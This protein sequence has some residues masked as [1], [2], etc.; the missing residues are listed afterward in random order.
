MGIVAKTR[1]FLALFGLAVLLSRSTPLVVG[2]DLT[3]LEF[4]ATDAEFL[5]PERGFYRF[6]DLTRPTNFAE[7]RGQGQTLIYGRVQASDFRDRPLS[8]EFLDKIQAG[9]DETRRQGLKVKF[10]LA[11]N[12]G[13]DADAP[14][15]VILNHIQQL[16][17]LWEKNKDVMFHMDAGF[18]GAW[19]EWHS[20]TNGLD[21]KNDR[22]DILFAILDALPADRTVGIRTPH[23]KREAFTGSQLSNK[24][25]ITE[26]NAFDGSH[27]AR[28]G[29]LNDC[30]LSSEDDV[31]T[32]AL[33]NNN[34]PLERELDYIGGE[35][36]YVPFGGE[37]CGLHDRGKSQ[38]ALPEMAQL[39]I[40][41]LNLDYHP[42]VIRRWKEEGSFDE[43]QRRLGYRFELKSAGLPA[44]LRPGGLMPL[45]FTIDNVGFGELFNP[46]RMEVTLRNN[47]TGELR[48]A[49]LRTDPRRWTGGETNEVTTWLVV[50]ETLPTGK[51]SVGLWLPDIDPALRDDVRYSIR[52]ANEQVWD[53]AT[54][55]NRLTSDFTI[56]KSAAGSVYE[57]A[58]TFREVVDPSL[59]NLK[60][61]FDRD[62]GLDA[63]DVDLLTAA[64][65][66][67]DPVFDLN[68]DGAVSQLD[69]EIWV[70]DL[71][72]TNFGDADLNGS[73]RVR[74]LH[75]AFQRIRLGW[76]LGEREF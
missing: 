34:W 58:T 49:A 35:S 29:H 28:V 15:D 6:R 38:N 37:T 64:V 14:K 59:L 53:A 24:Q 17:P 13:F 75:A 9:F 2:Q 76:G 7:V 25:V 22:H 63:D 42:D 11:Y 32:Y 68:R 23:F 66:S 19:G 69:R 62:G 73:S 70:E 26:Q 36:Q 21:N 4:Q 41:Y 40:D 20:S 61:D 60:G 30:F 31:G 48:T 74:G 8:Q 5:N 27:L 71:A 39:H 16:K 51:Y 1:C 55:I 67:S 57:T 3:K 56:S 45:E 50:P 52:F 12:N 44:E 54:G 65:G 47:D 33:L 10:R 72:R 46:R 18:I 43:I